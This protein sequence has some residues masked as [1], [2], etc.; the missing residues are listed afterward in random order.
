M[1]TQEQGRAYISAIKSEYGITYKDIA[2]MLEISTSHLSLYL[3]GKRNFKRSVLYKLET[4][5]NSLKGEQN[6]YV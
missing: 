6:N 2:D 5:I 4:K 1:I 3:N